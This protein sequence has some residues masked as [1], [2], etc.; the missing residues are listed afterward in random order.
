MKISSEG[1]ESAALTPVVAQ[2]M[3]TEELVRLMLGVTGKDAERVRE[4][5]A[6]GSL[7]SGASRFRWTG[8]E[9]DAA[10]VASF[11]TRYPDSDPSIRFDAS[12][13]TT[14]ILKGAGTRPLPVDREA[15]MKKRTFRRRS[16]WDELL[17][18]VDSPAY[19][20]YSHKERVDVFRQRLGTEAQ[21]RLKEAAKLI[22]YSSYERQV[23]DAP[24]DTVDLHVPRT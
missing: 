21:R 18:L 4:L 12:R 5:L 11:L 1:I 9:A 13:C 14:V 3:A 22:A 16:F 7:V 8:V 2:E 20:E 23:A 24:F 15:G 10:E 17:A 6:R 19:V